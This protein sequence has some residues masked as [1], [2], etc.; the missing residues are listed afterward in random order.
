M[1]TENSII[2]GTDGQRRDLCIFG[3]FV[4][5]G[6]SNKLTSFSKDERSH[7]TKYS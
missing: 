3:T 4:D 1:G 6:K 7:H 2:E 5:S